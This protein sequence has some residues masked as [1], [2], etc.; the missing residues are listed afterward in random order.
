M[1]GEG[2]VRI[3]DCLRKEGRLIGP[4]LPRH[5]QNSGR[6]LT[7][8]TPIS[9]TAGGEKLLGVVFLTDFWRWLFITGS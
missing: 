7:T 1:E 8:P 2:T 5:F 6:S 4:S 3:A 9:S